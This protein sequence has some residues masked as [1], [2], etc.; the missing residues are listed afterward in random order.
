MSDLVKHSDLS[1]EQMSDIQKSVQVASREE[2]FWGKFCSHTQ[3][4]EGH[5]A[6]EWRKLVL[7]NLTV[8][9]LKNLSEGHTPDPKKLA[10]VNFKSTVESYGNW[11]PYTD[12]SKRYNFDD[13]VKDAKTVLADDASQQAELRRGLQFVAGTCTITAVSGTNGFVKTLLKARTILSKNK[14]K[15]INGKYMCILSSEQAADVLIENA[16]A[17]THTSQKE[18][19]VEGYIG[20]LAGF[21]LYETTSEAIYKDNSTA[22]CLFIGK[23]AYGMPVGTVSIGDSSVETYDNPLGSI[24][25]YF[26]GDVRPDSLH[27]RGSVGYK[28]M[29]F[30]T[31]VVADECILRAEVSITKVEESVNPSD[32]SRSHYE[33]ISPESTKLVFSVLDT[34]DSV[35]S[36]AT[37][38]LKKGSVVGSGD[39]VAVASQIAEVG[40]GSFNYVVAQSGKTFPAGVAITITSQDISR[41]VKAIVVK[42]TA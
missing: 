21:V 13:V 35:I 26:E 1:V 17:I 34:D 12:E 31:R 27:Q 42:A 18:A 9:D 16:A 38:T 19:L 29:G 5:D 40:L 23:S 14:A 37:I 6:I 20:E 3:Y 22:Y 15:T 32:E 25:E 39:A 30:G 41:G 24:P 33:S 7:T 28:V 36:G 2:P 10:Y 4:Q 11:I 8:S